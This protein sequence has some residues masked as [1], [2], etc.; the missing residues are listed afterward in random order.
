MLTILLGSEA[1]RWTPACEDTDRLYDDAP[2]SSAAWAGRHARTCEGPGS[3]T[4]RGL[5]VSCVCVHACV[6]GVEKFYLSQQYQW[7]NS[8]Q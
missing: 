2:V 6:R 3:H 5:E 8:E 1:H 7:L 4:Q